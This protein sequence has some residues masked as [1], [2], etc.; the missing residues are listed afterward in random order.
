MSPYTVLLGEIT[1]DAF[2]E[3]IDLKGLETADF[4][5]SQAQSDSPDVS[6]DE[7]GVRL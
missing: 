3:A 4:G 7:G 5:G 2:R 6:D 1:D